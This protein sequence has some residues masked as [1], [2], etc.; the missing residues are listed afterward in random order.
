MS[1]SAKEDK[2]ASPTTAATKTVEHPPASTNL[3]WPEEATDLS[4][5]AKCWQ[6]WSYSFMNPLLSKGSKQTLDDGTHLSEEDLYR[7]PDSLKSSFLVE[8]F[9]YVFAVSVCV[10]ACMHSSLFVL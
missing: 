6:R 5:V 3:P 1:A 8:K 2:S 4:I 9:E 10:R 7:V